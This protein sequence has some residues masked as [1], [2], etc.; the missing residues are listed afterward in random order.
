MKAA[1]AALLVV[2]LIGLTGVFVW[3]YQQQNDPVRLIAQAAAGSESALAQLES[4]AAAGELDQYSDA[5]GQ[6]A[7]ERANA[8]PTIFD[9]EDPVVLRWQQLFLD[10]NPLLNA[11]QA[12]RTE[13]AKAHI[14]LELIGPSSINPGREHHIG[15]TDAVALRDEAPA[16]TRKLKIS[17]GYDNYFVNDNN[18]FEGVQ[19]QSTADIQPPGITASGSIQHSRVL[20]TPEDAPAPGTPVSLRCEVRARLED[21]THSPP[22]VFA[23][24]TEELTKQAFAAGG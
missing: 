14:R 17:F 23:E 19:Q 24:W 21:H 12:T 5:I 6:A 20:I 11:S 10:T 4:L 22:A 13:F 15:V 1:K 18:I 9:S 7:T 8:N 16:S 3:N 2:A